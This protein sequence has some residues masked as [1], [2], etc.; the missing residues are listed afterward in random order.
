VILS[1]ATMRIL[2]AILIGLALCGCSSQQK[3]QEAERATDDFYLQMAKGNYGGI[4]DATGDPFKAVTSRNEMI[5]L[6]QMVSSKMGVCGDAERLG[7]K[8]NYLTSGTFVAMQYK[9][10][11][12]NGPVQEN[13]N[14]RVEDGKAVMY[15]YR[16]NSP[17]LVK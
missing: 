6:L 14:W 5:A 1:A 4:Y 8:V 17:L 2:A 3:F 9:R 16:A 12:A 11:C 15:A 7:F 10:K 13:F